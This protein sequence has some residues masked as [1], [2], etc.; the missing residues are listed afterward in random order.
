MD[1][2]MREK[3][4]HIGRYVPLEVERFSGMFVEV[5]AHLL[6][7]SM[8]VMYRFCCVLLLLLRVDG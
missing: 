8:L 6:V 7:C 3:C 5:L 2:W 1:I 4:Q